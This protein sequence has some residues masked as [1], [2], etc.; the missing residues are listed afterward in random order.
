MFSNRREIMSWNLY[1]PLRRHFLSF[2]LKYCKVGP[3]ENY[4]DHTCIDTPR[5]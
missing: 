4:I 3:H 2:W 1:Q 5:A